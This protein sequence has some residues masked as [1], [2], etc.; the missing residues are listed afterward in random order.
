ARLHQVLGAV[1]ETDVAL[2][3]DDGHVA[4]AQ[5]A[6]LG[7]RLVGSWVV[8]VRGCDPRA[9][10][11]QLAR[12]GAVPRELVVAV[13]RDDPR[14]DAGNGKALWR[15]ELRGR[16]VGLAA[17]RGLHAAPRCDSARIAHRP[18]PG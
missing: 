14:V 12:S 13:G 5:P 17:V 18:G 16:A 9:A 6:V 4:R 1:D 8:V 15:A 3:T 2:G 7:E 11:L 10:H